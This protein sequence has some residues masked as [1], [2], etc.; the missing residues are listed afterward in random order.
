[1]AN[2]TWYNLSLAAQH[3]TVMSFD[4]LGH[5]A[6]AFV[7]VYLGLCAFS[8]QSVH[9]SIS[10]IFLTLG[11]VMLGRFIHVFL[12]SGLFKLCMGRN[13][14]VTLKEQGIIWLGGGIRGAVAFA[15]ILTVG[16]P[17]AKMLITTTLGLVVITTVVFGAIMPLWCWLCASRGVLDRRPTSIYLPAD[18]ILTSLS[19]ESVSSRDNSPSFIS[20]S[21]QQVLITSNDTK[22]KSWIHKKWNAFDANFLKPV[23]L[24]K[25]ALRQ[26]EK[27]QE[28]ID[29]LLA[30]SNPFASM[31]TEMISTDVD[32]NN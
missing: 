24:K 3:G 6:E 4:M 26:Q 18:S 12:M 22:P 5:T 27:Q 2:Y 15:L 21:N 16:T 9:W 17:K 10:F 20:H 8:Y 14:T 1:M 19:D 31:E 29:T 30:T 32:S 25:S 23:V 7:F 13:F 28:E 11:V